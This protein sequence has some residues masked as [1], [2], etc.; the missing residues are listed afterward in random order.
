M[1]LIFQAAALSRGLSFPEAQTPNTGE[2]V[3]RRDQ[4]HVL[5]T[6][7]TFWCAH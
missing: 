6:D 7:E 3:P 4:P 2:A 5:D 1:V